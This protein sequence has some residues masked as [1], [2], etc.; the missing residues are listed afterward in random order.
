MSEAAGQP[1]DGPLRKSSLM[2]QIAS[3]MLIFASPF[4]LPR[5]YL[6]PAGAAF[7]RNTTPTLAG[8]AKLQTLLAVL[9]FTVMAFFTGWPEPRKS[10]TKVSDPMMSSSPWGPL[11]D[12]PRSNTEFVPVVLRWISAVREST[13]ALT[14]P[15]LPE[16]PGLA[17][18]MISVLLK[19][20]AAGS[21]M[22]DTVVPAVVTPVGEENL[23]SPSIPIEK[24]Q[25]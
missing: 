6:A 12:R 2:I 14:A 23:R 25:P 1:F 4:R 21:D 5:T 15:F 17:G 11:A 3:A 18:S 7:S 13:T 22:S 16:F 10:S 19:P 24:D 20:G 9:P 8:V